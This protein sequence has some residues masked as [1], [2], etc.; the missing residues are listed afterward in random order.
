MAECLEQMFQRHKMYCHDQKVKGLNPSRVNL[1]VCCISVQIVRK[2][3]I[4]ALQEILI[5]DN[6]TAPEQII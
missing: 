4:K 5:V 6:N 1:G 3:E 2:A